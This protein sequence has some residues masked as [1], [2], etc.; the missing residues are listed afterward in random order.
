MYQII[1]FGFI[2]SSLAHIVLRRGITPNQLTALSTLL[3]SLPLLWGSFSDYI[4][5][6]SPRIVNAS[7]QIYLIYLI[8][9]TIFISA[10][11]LERWSRNSRP[12]PLIS[13]NENSHTKTTVFIF[14]MILIVLLFD[15]VMWYMDQS[16]SYSKESLNR[17]PGH[18]IF[19]NY[20]LPVCVSYF[21]LQ[22]KRGIVAGLILMGLLFTILTKSRSPIAF[23]LLAALYVYWNRD[24]TKPISRAL[25]LLIG[26]FA[27]ALVVIVN[28][29]LGSLLKG[30]F[31]SVFSQLLTA[32][33]YT[34]A[35][36]GIQSN[37]SL[38]IANEVLNN[39]FRF[40]FYE[41]WK[42]SISIIPLS[43]SLFGFKY[44][45]WPTWA[46]AEIAPHLSYG[47]AGNI[48]AQIYT[49]GGWVAIFIFSSF[50]ALI[51]HLVLAGINTKRTLIRLASLGT[52]PYISFFFIRQDLW[53]TLSLVVSSLALIVSIALLAAIARTFIW[54]F[55]IPKERSTLLIK[56]NTNIF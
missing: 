3:F 13:L 48:Y 45:K 29:F 23:A 17:I 40:S 32:E 19:V 42:G 1:F 41:F 52:V 39:D 16:G 12:R 24:F 50:W 36:Y 8:P 20:L 14:F 53:A 56:R 44:I 18:H 37:I 28:Q 2:L 31:Y 6:G 9:A 21:M 34:K 43:E 35:I 11:S 26:G 27:V 22:R 49:V 7:A 25:S 5:S 38:A 51:N 4:S 55:A 10:S 30:D 54:L 46:H 47:I 15:Q 33:T